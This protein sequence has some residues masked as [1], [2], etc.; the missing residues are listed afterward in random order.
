MFQ[1]KS[2][3]ASAWPS[4]SPDLTV[5]GF[6]LWDNMKD[7]MYKTNSNTLEEVKQNIKDE[8]RNITVIELNRVNQNVVSRCLII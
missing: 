4:R 6:Y 8:I 5:C 7:K 2:D 1:D 3:S